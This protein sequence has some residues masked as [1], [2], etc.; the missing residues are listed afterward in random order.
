MPN[1][2]RGR[3]DPPGRAWHGSEL[4]IDRSAPVYYAAAPY[5][6]KPG[7][8]GAALNH[9]GPN[10]WALAVI[11]TDMVSRRHWNIGVKIG[12]TLHVIKICI[13]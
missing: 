11:F 6:Q 10:S 5:V 2:G 8:K 4:N 1:P 7:S 3:G 13:T 9:T 12:G